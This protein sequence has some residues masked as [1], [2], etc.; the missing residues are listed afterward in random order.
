MLTKNSAQFAQLSSDLEA[1]ERLNEQLKKDL[2]LQKQSW[3][4]DIEQ[5]TKKQDELS[6]SIKT[7]E[8]TI[9]EKMEEISA[10]RQ[11]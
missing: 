5:M 6:A 2:E 9:A 8:A 11:T 4:A 1:S 3:D 10:G 7:L